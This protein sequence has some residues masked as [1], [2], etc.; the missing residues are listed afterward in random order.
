[1]RPKATHAA[2]AL[3]AAA[4]VALPAVALAARVPGGTGARAAQGHVVVLEDIRFHPASLSIR[5]GESVTWEWR[6]GS[7]EHNV[8]GSGFHSRTQSSG[9]FTVR[10]QRAGTFSYRCTIHAAEGMRG[11]VLVH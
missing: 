1:M 9:S 2:M 5:R 8:A 7:V 11:K 6:D 4:A 3:S 10:F